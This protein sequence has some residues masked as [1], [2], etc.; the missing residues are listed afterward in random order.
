MKYYKIDYKQNMAPIPKKQFLLLLHSDR[1]YITWYES[2][3][4]TIIGDCANDPILVRQAVRSFCINN[5]PY[6]PDSFFIDY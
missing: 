6:D 3:H 5:I 1:D 2:E 4:I